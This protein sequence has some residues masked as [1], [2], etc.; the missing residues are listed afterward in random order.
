MAASHALG[1]APNQAVNS[2]T[3]DRISL[4]RQAVRYRCGQ[5]TPRRTR[6]S[7]P[8]HG[9][10]N[11]KWMWQLPARPL[12]PTAAIGSDD[13]IPRIGRHQVLLLLHF[14]P[15]IIK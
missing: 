14:I 13:I 6:H 11:P 4:R 3:G 9:I 2:A 8:G 12:L 5:I 10:D 15:D 1:C 7:V